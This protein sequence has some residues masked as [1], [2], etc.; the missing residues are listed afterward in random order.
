MAIVDSA[1]EDGVDDQSEHSAVVQ[2]AEQDATAAPLVRRGPV[3]LA[4]RDELVPVAAL[5][6]PPELDGLATVPG[7]ALTP[8]APAILP[9]KG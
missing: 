2:T 4:V 9:S 5:A 7:E 3:R 6:I 1:C 8:M